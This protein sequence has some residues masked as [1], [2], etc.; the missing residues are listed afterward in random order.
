[1]VM[2]LVIVHLLSQGYSLENATD[3]EAEDDLGRLLFSFL[4][5]FGNFFD[6]R[7]AAISIKRVRPRFDNDLAFARYI[8]DENRS[9]PLQSVWSDQRQAQSD[10]ATPHFT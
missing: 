9:L 8:A 4:D 5:W 7:G 2:N 10:T 3:P 1:M 6:S